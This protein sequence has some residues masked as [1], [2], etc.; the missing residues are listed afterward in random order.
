MISGQSASQPVGGTQGSPGLGEDCRQ[1][2]ASGKEES[3]S[4]RGLA[5]WYVIHAPV[6]ATYPF[7]IQAIIIGLTESFLK[8]MKEEP[9][10]AGVEEG[11][12][13]I[14]ILCRNT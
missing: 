10:R 2:M 13:M 5:L 12:L 4:S 3:V 1:L 9:G 11:V 8:D 7:H 6:M 14:K